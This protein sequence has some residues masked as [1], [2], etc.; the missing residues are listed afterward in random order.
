MKAGR[1]PES[2]EVLYAGF[3]HLSED[4]DAARNMARPWCAQW[5][6]EEYHAQWL[7]EAGLDIPEIEIPPEL[8][9]LY[10]DIP[11]AEDCDEAR[12]LTSFLS[13]EMI[14]D[15]C[16]VIGIFGTPEYCVRRLKEL[17]EYGVQRLFLRTT[18]SYEYP[19]ALVETFRDN[20]LP[21]LEASPR[22]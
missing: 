4:M 3:V 13:D 20:V 6:V 10:P 18:S 21:R 17:D 16:E 2:L 9:R 11:H 12:R 8:L 5:A 1:D 19:E 15:I 14:A 7:R 22:P